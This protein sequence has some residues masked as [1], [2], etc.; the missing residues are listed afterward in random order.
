MGLR[1][2]KSDILEMI[3]LSREIEKMN[4]LLILHGDAEDCRN[5]NE[6][7]CS[8]IRLKLHYAHERFDFLKKKWLD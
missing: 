8:G 4:N 1:S 5:F 6:E 3:E 7:R 2:L